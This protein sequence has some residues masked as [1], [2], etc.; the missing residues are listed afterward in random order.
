MGSH[1]NHTALHWAAYYGRFDVVRA[2]VEALADQ[3]NMM[4]LLSKQDSLGQTALHKA[5]EE[6]KFA[7]V[8]VLLLSVGSILRSALADCRS[9][10]GET[11]K[12]LAMRV[13]PQQHM[14]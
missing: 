4:W 14:E 5:A 13:H 1:D 8:H 3:D 9:N 7:A 10:R 12:E 6:G 2:F 11:A